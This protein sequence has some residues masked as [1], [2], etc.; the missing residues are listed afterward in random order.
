[1]CSTGSKISM[2]KQSNAGIGGRVK[3]SVLAPA[4]YQ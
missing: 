1:M 3:A 2:R 4:K